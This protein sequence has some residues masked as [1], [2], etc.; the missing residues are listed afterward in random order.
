MRYETSSGDLSV[1]SSFS[2]LTLNCVSSCFRL[3]S[4]LLQRPCNNVTTF[5]RFTYSHISP[6]VSRFPEK[7]VFRCRFVAC[8]CR[9]AAKIVT[10][11]I[12]LIHKLRC[13]RLQLVRNIAHKRLN[14]SSKITRTRPE[15]RRS[16]HATLYHIRT[17][18]SRKM[19]RSEK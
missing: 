2:V 1:L 12:Q 6:S 17:L 10:I 9:S 5:R 15:C 16:S 8:Q 4:P 7:S 11:V 3:V 14:N 13:A 19:F 18:L